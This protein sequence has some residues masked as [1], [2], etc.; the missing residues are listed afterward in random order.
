VNDG[1]NLDCTHGVGFLLLEFD[2][3]LDDAQVAADG[4]FF[5]FGVVVIAP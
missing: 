3:I 1:P 4:D 5:E 2:L